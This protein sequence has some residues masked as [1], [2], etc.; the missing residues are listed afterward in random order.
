MRQEQKDRILRT[1]PSLDF[2]CRDSKIRVVPDAAYCSRSPVSNADLGK[3]DREVES[4]RTAGVGVDDQDGHGTSRLRF[5]PG[6]HRVKWSLVLDATIGC[7]GPVVGL[8]GAVW[9]PALQQPTRVP[10]PTLV[11]L[12][13][14]LIADDFPHAV[15]ERRVEQVQA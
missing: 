7:V 11:D 15:H 10:C 6:L 4:F 9:S 3:L 1:N 14:L 12:N 8:T 2:T 13:G 5:Y